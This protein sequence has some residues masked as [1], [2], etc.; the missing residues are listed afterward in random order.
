[1]GLT[2]VLVVTIVMGIPAICLVYGWRARGQARTVSEGDWRL[3]LPTPRP[4]VCNPESASRLWI[5]NSGFSIRFTIF[6]RTSTPILGN[7]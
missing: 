1:M 4:L 2:G 3:K 6:R 5:P 7:T